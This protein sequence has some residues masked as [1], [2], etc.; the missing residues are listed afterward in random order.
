[1]DSQGRLVLLFTQ[2][3]VPLYRCRWALAVLTALSS[4]ALLVATAG[5]FRPAAAVFAIQAF[6][7]SWGLYL[8][9][10]WFHPTLGALNVRPRFLSD[11]MSKALSPKRAAIFL[12]VFL[13][14]GAVVLP[15]AMLLASNLRRAAA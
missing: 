13:L 8:T 12:L 4:V 6:T 3:A 5:R 14:A 11:P 9:S 1:M 2:W 10:L 7:F 15:A